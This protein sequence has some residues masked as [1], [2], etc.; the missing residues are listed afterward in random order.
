MWCFWVP[1]VRDVPES[2]AVTTVSSFCNRTLTIFGRV[3]SKAGSMHM[4]KKSTLLPRWVEHTARKLKSRARSYSVEWHQCT[5]TIAVEHSPAHP[6]LTV[7]GDMTHPATTSECAPPAF[8]HQARS[9]ITRVT[10]WRM[11]RV[12]S[13]EM[14]K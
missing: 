10:E 3:H 13:C 7:I 1:K 6:Y 14:L 8:N 12:M 4:G 2:V 9:P 5:D 11:C